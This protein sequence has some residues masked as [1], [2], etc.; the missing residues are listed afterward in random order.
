MTGTSLE[1]GGGIASPKAQAKIICSSKR[2]TRVAT[3]LQ[4]VLHA[5][6]MSKQFVCTSML[7]HSSAN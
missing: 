4:D 3:F 6:V 5:I 1:G 2:P 7:P